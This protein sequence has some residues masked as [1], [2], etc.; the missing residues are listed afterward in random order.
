MVQEPL[1][2]VVQEMD[3][4]IQRINHYPLTMAISFPNTY[5]VDSAIQPLNNWG[6]MF[7]DETN[8]I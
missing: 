5:P 3:N 7:K 6:L 1:A 8:E 4:A 2:A